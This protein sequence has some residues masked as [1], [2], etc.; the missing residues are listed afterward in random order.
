MATNL[1]CALQREYA[2]WRLTR[3]FL[4]ALTQSQDRGHGQLVQ[5]Q[6]R[7]SAEHFLFAGYSA[8]GSWPP[9]FSRTRSRTGTEGE[10]ADKWRKKLVLGLSK[11][12]LHDA[13]ERMRLAMQEVE[14]AVELGWERVPGD[15]RWNPSSAVVDNDSI[16]YRKFRYIVSPRVKYLLNLGGADATAAMLLRYEAA[17]AGGTQWALPLEVYKLLKERLGCRNE[18]FASPVNSRALSLGPD[19]SF[20]TLFQDTDGVFGSRGDFF[21]QR[22]PGEHGWVLNPPFD[23]LT[24]YRAA[25][26]AADWVTRYPDALVVYVSRQHGREGEV[27]AELDTDEHQHHT[28]CPYE[29]LLRHALVRCTLPPGGHYYTTSRGEDV[30]ARFP[31]EV[32]V[33]AGASR[34]GLE[35]TAQEALHDLQLLTR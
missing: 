15:G 17:L 12:G 13:E 34:R 20:C 24:M 1:Q 4:W 25:L 35:S 6:L 32:I 31:T 3:R 18:G 14:R 29:P 28:S 22:G 7:G 2:Q 16:S 19:M 5:K 27:A 10:L 33:A 9:L 8:Q 30:V 26:R 21:S 23:R 11:V